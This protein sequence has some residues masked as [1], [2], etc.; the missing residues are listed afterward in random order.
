MNEHR[1]PW[2]MAATLAAAAFLARRFA[3]AYQS[4]PK[5]VLHVAL[6]PLHPAWHQVRNCRVFSRYGS[7]A[8]TSLSMPVILVHGFGV[9]CD[10]FGP[11]AERLAA[12]RSV[13]APDLPGHGRSDTPVHPLDVPSL[14]QA[15]LDWMDSVG[16]KKAFLVGQSMGVQIAVEAVHRQPRR[17]NGLILIGPTRDPRA[18]VVLHAWRLLMVAPFERLSLFGILIRDYLRMGWRLL[19]ECC[20]MMRDPVAAKL[21]QLSLPIMLIKGEHDA[22]VPADWLAYLRRLTR[23]GQ[24]FIIPGKGH[25]VHHSAPDEAAHAIRAFLHQVETNPEEN[26]EEREGRRS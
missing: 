10:Y 22:I 16:I 20:A 1:F 8:F 12:D 3:A 24:V 17:F 14:A 19:P 13:Y 7:P 4:R 26:R 9:S 21:G 5:A 18:G 11:L 23:A 25:A 2:R 15:L 6:R